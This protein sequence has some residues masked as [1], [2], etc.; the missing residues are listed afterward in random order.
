VT[1]EPASFRAAAN[2]AQWDGARDF[3]VLLTNTPGKD[4]YPITATV[5]A[6]VHEAASSTRT[7]AALD[8]FRWAFEH[9][10]EI[11]SELGYVPLPPALA[12]R[13]T[14]SWATISKR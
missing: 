9:G 8:F 2:S 14:S 7:G 10:A 4:V 1:P 3:Y 12:R 6:L 11:A 13:V 5:F